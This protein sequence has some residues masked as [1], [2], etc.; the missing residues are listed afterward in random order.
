[1]NLR[2]EL[3]LITQISYRNKKRMN[4]KNIKGVFDLC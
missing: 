3:T 1:M 2:H 4:T